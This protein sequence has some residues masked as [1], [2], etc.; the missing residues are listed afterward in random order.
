MPD[1][2]WTTVVREVALLP[3]PRPYL[4]LLGSVE[5]ESYQIIGLGNELLGPDGFRICDMS[6]S[7][8]SMVSIERQTLS[9]LH[10]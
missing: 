4:L 8:R 6:R 10:R 9:P 7:L 5:P 3:T 2:A 1:S